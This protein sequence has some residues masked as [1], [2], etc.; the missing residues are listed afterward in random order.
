MREY[1]GVLRYL[2]SYENAF[3]PSDMPAKI[4]MD[5]VGRV[6]GSTD[7]VAI[8]VEG[9]S[10]TDLETIRWIKKFQD[11]EISHHAELTR[12]T[13]IVTYI[14]AYNNGEMPETQSQLDTILDKIPAQIKKPYLGGSMN[15]VIQFG[16]VKLQS[17]QQAS[18][19]EQMI[20]DMEFL[21]PPVGITVQPTGRF[22][23]FTTLMHDLSSSKESMTYLGFILVFIYLV[24]VYRHFHAV[25]PL[26]PIIAIVGWNAV[27]MYVLGIAYTPMTATMG[28]MTIG[29]AA[30]YTILVM[31]RYAEEEE[32]L[33]EPIAAIQESVQKIG[34]AITVSGL[35]T[36][37]GFSA[38]CLA[39]FPIISN[40][41]IVTLIAVGLSLLGAIF[42][43]P[44]VLS[45]MG[46]FTVW[47]DTRKSIISE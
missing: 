4:Q 10:V 16:C 9:S 38:L 22:D 31:E 18:L 5:K 2:D 29:V 13:G 6:I 19:K 26:V 7:S 39:G 8:F 11:Y 14:L 34:T 20:S 27:A 42:I 32:R 43:M 37:F 44:A 36:F 46:Q 12:V 30:E 23:L 41:G 25:S 28:S 15:T 1:T 17:T 40:F 3:V 35:A 24:L 45:I 33:H 47:L 21:E